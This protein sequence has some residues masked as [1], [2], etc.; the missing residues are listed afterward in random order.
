MKGGVGKTSLGGLFATY[1]VENGLPVV[2]FDANIQRSLSRH[3]N[4]D[5][6][7]CPGAQLPWSITP[8][9]TS[10]P[11][12]VR[13]MMAYLKRIEGCVIIDT[14]G[15]IQDSSLKYIFNA[16]DIA[17]VPIFYDADTIDATLLFCDAF[18]K[19][20]RAK[21]FFVPNR[22]SDDKDKTQRIRELRKF[23]FEQLKPFGFL[24]ARIIEGNSVRNYSTVNHLTYHQ[25]LAVMNAFRPIVNCIK[26][27]PYDYNGETEKEKD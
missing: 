12:K 23:A 19:V 14:P 16:A 5:L 20:S 27:L 25:N 2:V 3:R 10:D 22:I 13:D 7:E 9:Q 1:L 24:T 15:N 11:N 21:M 18:R 17:L 8:L 26:G 6:K 4:R